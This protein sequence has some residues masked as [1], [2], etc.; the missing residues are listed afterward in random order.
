MYKN[1]LPDTA[2]KEDELDK[3]SPQEK[4]EYS[5]KR[6]V[7]THIEYYLVVCEPVYVY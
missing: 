2:P 1:L 7:I 5:L 4:A 3:M 6:Y